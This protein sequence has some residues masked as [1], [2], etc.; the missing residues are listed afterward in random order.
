[1]RPAQGRHEAARPV[2]DHDRQRPGLRTPLCRP[3]PFD[4]EYTRDLGYGAVKFLM[5]EEAGKYGAI[6]SV[7]GGRLVP[8]KFED[9]INPQTQRMLP[10][11]VDTASVTYECAREYMTRLEPSDFSDAEVL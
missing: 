4:A 3:I 7:V 2:G 10:R 6:V 1:P 5:S 9:M 11:V 8:L